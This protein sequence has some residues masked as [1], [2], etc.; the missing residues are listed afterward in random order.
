[1]FMCVYGGRGEGGGGGGGG[2]GADVK[3]STDI[4]GNLLATYVT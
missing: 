1:M 4:C 3:T 2:G